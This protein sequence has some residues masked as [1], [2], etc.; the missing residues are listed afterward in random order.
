[1]ALTGQVN[2]RFSRRPLRLN[3]P[4]IDIDRRTRV[5][6]AC[7]VNK[8]SRVY[9]DN[10]KERD[11]LR[12]IFDDPN[13]TEQ[14]SADAA[15]KAKKLGPLIRIGEEQRRHNHITGCAMR[16]LSRLNTPSTILANSTGT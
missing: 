2:E 10:P 8:K 12:A 13:S 1:V 14:D 4:L 3:F 16:R 7:G 9:E 6:T 5:A 15:R 11:R